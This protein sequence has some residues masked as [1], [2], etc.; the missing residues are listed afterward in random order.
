MPITQRFPGLKDIGVVTTPFGGAT[1]YERF[2]PAIDIAAPKGVPISAPISGQVIAAVGGKRQ[3]D[4]GYGNMVTIRTKNGDRHQFGHLEAPMVSRGQQVA[5]GQVVG[6]LGNSGGSYSPS[7]QGDGAHLDYR[8]VDA[9]QRYKNP[10]PFL[11]NFK[12]LY[13][14]RPWLQ[15]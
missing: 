7:G 14:Q 15:G 3:G 6:T 8:I 4:A 12:T 10:A 13:A 5:K 11:Q 2:H 1:K 9:Y